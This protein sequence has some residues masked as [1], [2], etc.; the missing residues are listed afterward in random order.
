M[1]ILLQNVR[2]RLFF[3]REDVWT[4]RPDVA[5][6]FQH[7]AWLRDFVAKHHLRE[8]QMVVK[9]EHPELLEV[10]PLQASASLVRPRPRMQA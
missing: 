8:V 5:F 4:A 6:D 9:F 2:S 7:A 10:V 3:C 1:K